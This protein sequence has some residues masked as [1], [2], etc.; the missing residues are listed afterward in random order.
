MVLQRLR[1]WSHGLLSYGPVVPGERLLLLQRLRTGAAYGAGAKVVLTART[2]WGKVV[3]EPLPAVVGYLRPFKATLGYML[4]GAGF[5]A[6]LF[7]A[8][9]RYHSTDLSVV[10]PESVWQHVLRKLFG[11]RPPAKRAG[12]PRLPALPAVDETR[13]AELEAPP[14]ARLSEDSTQPP[15]AETAA[16][17]SASGGAGPSASPA[18]GSSMFAGSPA[19]SFVD[20]HSSPPRLPPPSTEGPWSDVPLGG[21]ATASFTPE[22]W[23]EVERSGTASPHP[24]GSPTAAAAAAT[25]AAAAAAPGAKAMGTAGGVRGEGSTGSSVESKGFRGPHEGFEHVDPTAGPR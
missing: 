5:N 9:L 23:T 21:T 16:G 22:D 25:G 12:P 13:P 18:P 2:S 6:A 24:S 1:N 4:V 3:K 7:Y 14:P 20:V 17:G 8:Q 19:S 11:A 10:P 15:P